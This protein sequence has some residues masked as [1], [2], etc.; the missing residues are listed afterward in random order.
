MSTVAARA[1]LALT[2]AALLMTLLPGVAAAASRP[3]TFRLY[4]GSSCV[5][6]NSSDGAQVHLTWRRAS[7]KLVHQESYRA[8]SNGGYW[9]ACAGDGFTTPLLKGGDRLEARVGSATRKFAVPELTLR[10][11][12]ADNIFNGRAP[13]GTSI[14]LA[15]PAGIYADYE[16][17]RKVA[18]D[19]NGRWR[20]RE[21]GFDIMGG[22]YAYLRWK[23]AKGD[24]VTLDSIAPFIRITLDSPR[25]TG[26][27]YPAT[28][29]QA[30]LLDS[31]TD[32]QLGTA[33]VKA[34]RHGAY[35]G[36][37]RD[38]NGQL[39]PATAGLRLRALD[40]GR[41]ANWLIPEISGSADAGSDVVSGRCFDAGTSDRWYDARVLM[42]DG[43]TRAWSAGG[44]DADGTFTVDFGET[45]Y[46][47][48]YD[49]GDVQSGDTLLIGCLQQ[50]GDWVQRRLTVP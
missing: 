47:L 49:P 6:G 7:G 37:F 19:G 24:L 13:A 16:V 20:Y 14:R 29:V 9:E 35:G 22:Q 34:D 31:A 3:T 25:F 41:D 1:V 17:S 39:V 15:F 30:R 33:T 23:S 42:P 2:V 28:T 8:S 18:V 48:F 43:D 12:R 40:I 45:E 38:S 26:I 5:G 21:P 11:N 4:V 36:R 27:R 32:A 10:F 44:T 46:G 50:S